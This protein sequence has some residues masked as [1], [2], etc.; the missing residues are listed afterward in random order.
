MLR[1]KNGLV[2]YQEPN[3]ELEIQEEDVKAIVLSEWKTAGRED[4]FLTY[5]FI[6]ELLKND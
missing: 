4:H 1:I 5:K 3:G 2:E 6:K